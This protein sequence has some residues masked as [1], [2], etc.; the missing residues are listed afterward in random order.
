MNP[1]VLLFR[2]VTLLAL[3]TIF[4]NAFAQNHCQSAKYIRATIVRSGET[5]CALE[6]TV[7][8]WESKGIA[9]RTSVVSSQAE[10]TAKCD[11]NHVRVRLTGGSP[12]FCVTESIAKRWIQEKLAF[13][14]GEDEELSIIS[15]PQLFPEH[16]CTEDKVKVSVS[17]GEIAICTLQEIAKKWLDEG[18]AT[19]I[20]E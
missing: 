11:R 8:S 17:D 5:I 3:L 4:G 19:E 6:S 12:T 7:R 10:D 16:L 1:K 14:V 2:V 20:I 18:F 13:E 9:I 15:V